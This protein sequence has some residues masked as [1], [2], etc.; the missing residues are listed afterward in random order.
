MTWQRGKS[1]VE[2]LIDQGEIE[3]VPPSDQ[4][5]ERLLTEAQRHLAAATDIADQDPTGSFQLAYDAARKACSAPL[6]VQG[7][8][9]TTR[10]GHVAVEDVVRAQFDGDFHHFQRLRRKRRDSEYPDVGSPT[11]TVDDARDASAT[12]EKI[13]GAARRLMD[14]GQL[15]RF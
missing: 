13:L 11:T 7:L 12:A 9:P 4:L 1:E 15:D 10:R 2:G 8:R 3:R 5:A 14:S 6:A